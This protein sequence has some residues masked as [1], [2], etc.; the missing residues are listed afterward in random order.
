MQKMYD[1]H[2]LRQSCAA[3][4]DIGIRLLESLKL[5]HDRGVLLGDLSPVNVLRHPETGELT[6]IDLESACLA[7][8]QDDVATFSA[9]W[10]YPG[11]RAQQRS[12]KRLTR[13]DDYYAAGMLLY[14]VIC[15][16]HNIFDL[17]KTMPR[18]RF[19]DHFVEG[20]LPAEMASI[21]RKLWQGEAAAAL[22]DLHAF[23]PEKSIV[24][25]R[26]SPLCSS[27]EERRATTEVAKEW[28][29][30]LPRSVKQLA[31]NILASTDLSR[32]DRLWPA[33]SNV[34][35]TNALSLCHGACGVASFLQ[36]ALG[37]LPE[38]V[39]D[40]LLKHKID[41]SYYPPGLYTGSAGIAYAFGSF[42]WTEQAL[43]IMRAIP[44]APLAFRSPALF[45]GVAGWG[46]AA[47]AL[48]S[49]KQDEEFLAISEQAGKF[50]LQSKRDAPEGLYWTIDPS[51]PQ[52]L[53]M[54]YGA[55]GIG[56]FLLNLWKATRNDAYLHAARG[57]MEFEIAHA[58][59]NES[60]GSLLWGPTIGARV[61]SPYWLNG[62]GGVAS[63]L[64]R[65]YQALGD[66]R[67]LELAKRAALPCAGFFSIGPHLHEGLASMGE[68]LLDM[69][70]ATGEQAYF[71][72]ALF[73][74]RQILLFKIDQPDGIAFPGRHLL[75]V[76]HDYAT[77]GAGIGLFFLRLLHKTPRKLHDLFP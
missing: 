27:A 35:E 75:R 34:F 16:I 63:A 36:D 7:D 67:Y 3:W 64:V 50:L 33:D 59:E 10:A 26:S 5:V 46:L 15:P 4:R 12:V 37:A 45:D 14:N 65:F 19:L 29:D 49:I 21:I 76:S 58:E 1:A 43:S 57:A 71:N 41:P 32:E 73:K 17:D 72:A 47:L 18:E 48:F 66:K 31:Q 22:A 28:K 52:K 56:F 69:Y 55:T 40:W 68:T 30:E 6:F 39:L 44:G 2:G 62:C 13:H 25:L 24:D 9:G 38:P 74:S 42:G 53:A 8:A 20:G 61:H 11:F 51:E 70:Q 77:G 60:D 54:A 23:S